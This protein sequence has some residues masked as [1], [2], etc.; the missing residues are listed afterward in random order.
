MTVTPSPDGI[1]TLRELYT[2][3]EKTRSDMVLELEKLSSSVKEKFTEHDT[4]HVKHDV[5]H[6]KEHAHTIS[7]IRW[8]ITTI[9][10]VAGLGIAVWVGV[11]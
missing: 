10:A 2:L 6:D 1:V 3:I 7:M 9:I 5:M 4:V 11:K 8:A